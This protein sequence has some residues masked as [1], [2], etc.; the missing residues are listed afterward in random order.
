MS[1]TWTLDERLHRHHAD[2][3]TPEERALARRCAEAYYFFWCQQELRGRCPAYSCNG[4]QS[5]RSGTAIT[6]LYGPTLFAPITLVRTA[7]VAI[8]TAFTR[9][10]LQSTALGPQSL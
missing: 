6:V 7:F 9:P 1:R 10:G 3:F 8:E 2:D 4:L 5:K